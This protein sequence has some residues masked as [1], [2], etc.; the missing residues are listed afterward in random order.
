MCSYSD[1][2]YFPAKHYITKQALSNLIIT[3]CFRMIACL[4]CFSHHSIHMRASFLRK[5]LVS[6]LCL[7]AVSCSRAYSM[8]GARSSTP[9]LGSSP[10]S[11]ADVFMFPMFSDNYGYLIVKPG[12]KEAA[13]VDPGDGDAVLQACRSL[14]LDLVQAWCTHKHA[15]HVGGVATLKTALPDL[16]VI[17]TRYEEI[18]HA[19]RLVSDR[20]E[21]TFGSLRVRTLYTPCHT[22]GHVLYHVTSDSEDEHRAQPILFSG[23]TL[24][25]GGCG[26]FFEGNAA[27]MLKNM[28]LLATLPESSQVFCAHEYTEGNYKFL[29]SIAP[30]IVGDKFEGI[31]RMRE[32]GTPT[33][34]TSI[35]DELRFN[36][37]MQCNDKQLQ[38]RLGASSAEDAMRLLR[39]MKNN[40]K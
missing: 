30:E 35:A 33:V 28:D 25:V 11:V 15:D 26:R 16:E 8:A 38:E 7:S 31:R 18:P 1:Y 4:D 5:S 20:E 23:D 24:F 21:F 34:P 3:R 14:G 32:S 10:R 19:S 39:E 27:D 40:F 12:T 2:R 22:K 6:A 17:A 37:F 29:N 36:L 9:W 13:C